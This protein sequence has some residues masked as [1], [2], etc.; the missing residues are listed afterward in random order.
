MVKDKLLSAAS[1]CVVVG[2]IAALNDDVYQYSA[3]VLGDTSLTEL[4]KAGSGTLDLSSVMASTVASYAGSDMLLTF[5][6][7]GALVLI[8]LMFRT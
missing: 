3:K 1:V 4:S 6:G 8:G 5:S 7:L 2:G